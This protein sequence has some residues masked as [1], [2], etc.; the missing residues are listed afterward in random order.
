MLGDG[1]LVDI[2]PHTATKGHRQCLDAATDA[3]DG[4]LAVVGH[5]GE[6]QLGQVA[7]GIDVVQTVGGL[8]AAIEGVEVATTAEDE[9]ID[10]VEGI[11][12]GVRIGYGRDDD[13]YTAC[14]HD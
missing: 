12:E 9:G 13:G 7:L 1:L 8:L 3:E 11:D 2:L 5:L 4:H 10:M 6:H 14:R